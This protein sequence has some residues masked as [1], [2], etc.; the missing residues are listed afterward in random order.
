M[1]H[2]KE[3]EKCQLRA[4]ASLDQAGFVASK[5]QDIG[6]ICVHSPYEGKTGDVL[7]CIHLYDEREAKAAFGGDGWVKEPKSPRMIKNVD[8]FQISYD[9]I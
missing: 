3:I 8:G 2:E 1:K 7:A 4:K 9:H 5:C 6:M